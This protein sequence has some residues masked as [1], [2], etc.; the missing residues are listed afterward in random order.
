[1]VEIDGK[2]ANLAKHLLG[3]VF[4]AEN[5]EALRNSNGAVV[6]EKTGKYVKGKY[7]LTGGSVGLFEGKKI[8][9]AKNLEKLIEEIVAQEAIVIALKANIQTHHNEVIAFNEQ[10]KENAIKQIQQDI[11]NLTN[12]VFSLQNK[13]ENLT[14]LEETSTARITEL[15][16]QLE[17]N[18]TDI[19][20]TREMLN[21]FNAQ[22]KE[23]TEKMQLIEQDYATAEED[24][25]TA[26]TTFN[27]SNLQFT[28]QQSKVVSL[29]Q[30]FEFK[31]N[32]LNELTLQIE[33]STAQLTEASASITETAGQLKELEAMVITMLQNKETEEKALNQADQLYYNLR[34]ALTE[35]ENEIKSKLKSKEGIDTLL[36]EIKDR[37]SD[38]K[39]QLAGMKERL[40]V[41]FKVD[42]DVIIDEPRTT[43]TPLEELREKNERQRKR[44]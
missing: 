22:I 38:L 8:G 2:Y 41:E 3:N 14:H 9:R 43:D 27:D 44:L 28:K 32:Q 16:K 4:I 39:L 37:L 29:K 19:A 23:L 6:L 5:E 12:H 34:N 42:L 36:N 24:Y 10:L 15:E 40:N 35:K 25:N 18:H 20:S 26:T 13:I 7:S 21:S 1:V 31:T 11:N 17:T 33:S 30:E